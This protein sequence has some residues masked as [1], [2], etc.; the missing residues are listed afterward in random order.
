MQP[1]FEKLQTSVHKRKSGICIGLDPVM[2]LL[3]K[4][5]QS[6]DDAFYDFSVGIIDATSDLV[7]GY[8][9]NSAFFEALGAHGIASMHKIFSYIR[10]NYPDHIGILDA[11]R[12]DIGSTNAGYVSFA[13]DYLHA[14]AIT[15]HPYLGK[16]ALKP[17][18]D[19]ADRGAIILCRTSN[20]LSGE[21]QNLIIEN[22]KPLYLTVAQAVA[23]QWN[24]NK[25]CMLVVGATYPSELRRI[26]ESVGDLPLLVP[27]IGAQG[28][29]VEEVVSANGSL[30][31]T[32]LIISL[33]RSVIYADNS[34]S[35]AAAAR[36][37]VKQVVET[38]QRLMK[39]G[40]K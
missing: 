26:R 22:D 35:Y 24:D 7:M 13:Y 20:P 28:G 19:R 18:L 39:G 27:G 3:P 6:H 34:A 29:S 14:D 1:F 11:K 17:F 9:V 33:S 4:A 10:E 12:G 40:A 15:L 38:Y 31:T 5:L 30:D 36:E 21:F 8:K 25:N 23:K 2:Q 32:T 37:V 16:E